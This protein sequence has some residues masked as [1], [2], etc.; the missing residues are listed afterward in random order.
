MLTVRI[1]SQTGFEKVKEAE[2]VHFYPP[3]ITKNT[4]NPATL[5]IFYSKDSPETIDE[6]K[7]YVMN[8]N[9]KTVASYELFP[10]VYNTPIPDD[11]KFIGHS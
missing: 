7:V 3:V 5:H 2:S 8:E 1:V 10:S 6:G 9:G 4:G 11:Q